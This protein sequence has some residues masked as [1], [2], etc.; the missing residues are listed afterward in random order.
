VKSVVSAGKL[1]QSLK[2]RFCENSRNPNQKLDA[3]PVVEL[4]TI[5]SLD[6]FSVH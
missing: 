5:A 4:R 2:Q 1:S 3:E 6:A